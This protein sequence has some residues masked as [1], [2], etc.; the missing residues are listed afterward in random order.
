MNYRL[1][2]IMILGIVLL[3]LAGCGSAA[4]TPSGTPGSQASPSGSQA[5]ATAASAQTVHVTLSDQQISADR[6]TLYAGMPYHFVV[7]NTGQVTS[8]FIMGQGGSGWQ[9][10]RMPMGWQHQMMASMSYQIATGATQ[11]F[12]YTFPASAVGHPYG[13]GCQ[14]GRQGMWYPFTVQPQ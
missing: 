1:G 10:N 7:T 13:F 12:D 5:S 8:Q 11:T 2:F 9:D 3:V 14:M 6:S 4:S